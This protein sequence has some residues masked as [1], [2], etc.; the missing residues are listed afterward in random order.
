M[1]DRIARWQRLY[2]DAGKP[3]ARAF[4][5]YARRRGEDMTSTEAQEFVAQQATGQVF[6]GRLPSDGKV[7]A[8][9]SDMRFQADLLDFSKRA[10]SQGAGASRYAL[11]VTDLFTKEAW[12]ERMGSKTDAETKNAMR[13]IIA[14]NGTAPKEVSV[15]LGNE[16]GPTFQAFLEDQGVTI[17]KKDPQQV[18]ALAG[19]D[20]T[21][22]SIKSILKNIQGND[23]WAKHIKRA[24]D[25]YND[26]E[27]SA[28]YGAAPDDVDDNKVLQYH[29]EAEAGQAVKH[30]NEKW[31]QKARRLKQRGGFRV[32]LDRST[33][34][35]ID[36]PKFGGKV[37]EVEGLAGANVDDTEGNSFPVRQVLAVPRTSGDVDVPDELVPGS[38]KR[39]EQLVGMREFA[40]TLKAEILSKPSGEMS[41]A[42]V[43]QFLRTQPGFSD[44][45]DA[46]R[47][48]Q[49]GRNVKFLRLFG[50]EIRGAGPGMVVRSPASASSSSA[51]VRGRPEGAVDIMPRMPRRG[52]PASTP[53]LWTPDNP[54]R[55]GSAVHAR[56]E[57]YRSAT[58]VGEARRLGATPQDLKGDLEKGH[59]R[60]Q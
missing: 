13:K 60:L 41:F 27:H 7:T 10:S 54:H 24:V 5:T 45:A 48:P 21:Q 4:R 58:T 51:G 28:L 23:G 53:L 37:H 40:N 11:A 8:S 1:A 49:A 42:G 33:W 50:F 6:Q 44:T 16:F 43:S 47:L 32:P 26:R 3:G 38:G 19:I 18:N 36:A 52:L 30:N 59:A 17:R 46:Y 56:Y 55:P 22:Q 39:Q 29:L 15:D 25:I 57:R 12:I 31:R 35:R 2:E 20:R 34:E 14:K 9:R